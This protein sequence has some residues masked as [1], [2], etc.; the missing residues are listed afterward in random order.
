MS[1]RTVSNLKKGEKGIIKSFN[2]KVMSLKL[3][4]MGC[5]PGCEVRLD[6]VAPLGDPVCIN[7]GGNYC[8]SLRKNEAAAIEIE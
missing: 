1:V 5:I 4:E 2:D 3:L 7:I 6:A 8:L